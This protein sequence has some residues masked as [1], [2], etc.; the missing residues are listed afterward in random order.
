MDAEDAK[1][2]LVRLHERLSR[3]VAGTVADE[4]VRLGPEALKLLLS[5][6][7]PL[8]LAASRHWI[9]AIALRMKREEAI[10]ILLEG[11]SHPDWR[12]FQ[13]ARDTY[14]KMG[15]DGRDALVENLKSCDVVGGR[16]QTLYCLHRLA[17]PFG[18]LAIGDRTLIAPIAE[19]AASDASEEVRAMAVEVLSRSEAHDAEDTIAGALEDASESVRLEA[20]KA[21][22][23]L[24]LKKAVGALVEMLD[25]TQAEVR[26]DVIY[27][28]DRIGEVKSAS[29]VR[30]RLDDEDWY[31]RWA[32]AKALENLWEPEN[33]AALK[34][35]AEDKNPVVAVAA[36]ET[37][38]RKAPKEAGD[39]LAK[40]AKSSNESIRTTARHYAGG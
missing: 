14:A 30:G 29:A 39:T 35:A 31:V 6:P 19:A 7:E 33:V 8:V 13:V 9:V 28:L 40:A 27:S 2:T 22:G 4:L 26:A 1:Q 38:A 20:A 34:R 36:V 16:K 17:D 3:E 23:R 24:G 18:P 10:P 21:A 12:I 11:L 32:A 25:H 15:T 37:L 5:F